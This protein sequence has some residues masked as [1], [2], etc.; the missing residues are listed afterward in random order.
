M[1]VSVMKKSFSVSKFFSIVLVLLPVLAISALLLWFY[2]D[3]IMHTGNI[4]DKPNTRWVSKDGAISI[5]IG[6]GMETYP[7]IAAWG[8]CT[9]EFDSY[10]LSFEMRQPIRGYGVDLIESLEFQIITDIYLLSDD[11]FYMQVYRVY[12]QKPMENDF[13]FRSGKWIKFY[14]VDE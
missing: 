8:L 3:D 7:E 14:R 2:V 6:P 9:V 12:S 1:E 10:D 11:S 13:P 5:E 4:M